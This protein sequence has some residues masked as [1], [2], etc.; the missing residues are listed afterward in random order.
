ME[1]TNGFS[2]PAPCGDR[3]Q[4]TKVQRDCAP[5]LLRRLRDF[6]TVAILRLDSTSGVKVAAPVARQ[7]VAGSVALRPR[8]MLYLRG[9]A[10]A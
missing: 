5:A 9:L 3:L 6:G 2:L 10:A 8:Q 4:K 7:S 1:P